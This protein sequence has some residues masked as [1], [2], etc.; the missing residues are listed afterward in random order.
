MKTKEGLVLA[1]L[2]TVW[3]TASFYTD[4][5]NKQIQEV[6]PLPGTI[7]FLQ[8]LSGA[9]C[10]TVILRGLQ[11][12]PFLPLRKD[13]ISALLPI[14]CC[15]TLGF[16]ST[17]YSLGQSAVSFTHAIKATEPVFL[18][19]IASTFF[20]QTF[21]P[22]AFVIP[23]MLIMEAN[24]LAS[25]VVSGDWIR[26]V[27]LLLANGLLH[28]VYNQA[29]MLLLDR[30]AALS[31]SIANAIRRFAV[32]SAAVLYFGNK[33]S[34]MNILGVGIILIGVMLYVHAKSSQKAAP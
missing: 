4:A 22:L 17:N 20:K 16:V 7:T 14:A 24:V 5:F 27:P 29:S 13:Q 19:V 1:V 25:L 12:K 28:Y 3:Y 2:A 11:I 26:L 8:F 18:V 32:I 34:S 23:L 33:L 9:L 6:H 31:H 30:V 21:S 15:W 10:C